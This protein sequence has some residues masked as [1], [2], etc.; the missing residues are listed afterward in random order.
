VA[1]YINGVNIDGGGGGSVPGTPAEVLDDPSAPDTVVCLD[2]AGRGTA[3]TYAAVRQSLGL[4][5]RAIA[6]PAPLLW[7]R[8]DGR[9][10]A[11]TSV[12]NSGSAGV[13][14]GAL[15]RVTEGAAGPWGG[16]SLQ[17]G[18]GG[19]NGYALAPVD[20]ARPTAAITLCLWFRQREFAPARLIM[21]SYDTSWV[22]PYTA[23]DLYIDIAGKVAGGI[24]GGG[25]ERRVG[26]SAVA[27]IARPAEWHHAALTFD[28]AALRL[29]LD[30]VQVAAGSY[31]GTVDYGP[32]PG[33]TRWCVGANNVAG[34]PEPF[35]GNLCDARVLGVA[36]SAS[37]VAAL[38]GLWP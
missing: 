32:S 11:A 36:L 1:I 25:A 24:A 14:P 16:T 23:A 4:S 17:I 15:V 13:A 21:R 27:I 37:E 19:T 28:G 5:P 38:A 6:S 18:D 3:R 31:A 29:Y 7:Y 2:N 30:G 10:V 33:S 20:V 9:D 8:F 35:V 22:S 34:E 26:G 12:P